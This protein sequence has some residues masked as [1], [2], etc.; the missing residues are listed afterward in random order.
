[1]TKP[2]DYAAVALRLEEYNEEWASFSVKQ[3]IALLREH[4]RGE[5]VRRE[6]LDRVKRECNDFIRQKLH[7]AHG[8]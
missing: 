1:M 6:E 8:Q 3:A 7:G 4:A 5:W 2:I